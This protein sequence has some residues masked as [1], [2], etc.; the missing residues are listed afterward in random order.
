LDSSTTSIIYDDPH[1]RVIWRPGRSDYVL[2][3]FADLMLTVDGHRF[4]ADVP[5]AKLDLN[6]IGVV[7]TG[8]NFFPKPSLLAAAPA[9]L[10]QIAGFSQRI[11][12][13]G[14]M[15]GYAAVKYSALLGA[16]EVIALCPPWSIDAEECEGNFPGWPQLFIPE[17]RGMGTRPEEISGA[18]YVFAD[19]FDTVDRFQA[20]MIKRADPTAT[21]IN[22]PMVAHHVVPVFAGTQ[23]LKTLIDAARRR[24]TK[25]MIAMSRALRKDSPRRVNGLI[26]TTI[27]RH[28]GLTYRVMA[29]RPS[30]DLVI[31]A[32]G[33]QHLFPAMAFLL[34]HGETGAA[35]RYLQAYHHELRDPH[36]IVLAGALLAQ[37]Q[38]RL[39]G[40]KTHHQTHLVYD[41]A[42]R[43]CVHVAQ[44]IEHLHA[45]VRFALGDGGA[46]LFVELGGV[47]VDLH[48][49]AAFRLSDRLDG[50]APGQKLALGSPRNSRFTMASSGLFVSA[51][52]EGQ[53]MCNREMAYEWEQFWIG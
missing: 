19:M 26:T 40:V 32:L 22:V 6:C 34:R 38:G 48:V 3:T 10:A 51:E 12:Y 44:P 4:F 15:G 49:D 5:A 1:I 41:C 46:A 13:G 29:A 36:E 43:F 20:N 14:S 39:A 23:V 30:N 25:T 11:A 27:D 47:R 31:S 21:I 42:Q 9:I 50:E 37:L 35:I 45:P 2:I 28:P 18:V 8:G 52:P 16:T 17:M 7:A 33:A 24:D 53:V